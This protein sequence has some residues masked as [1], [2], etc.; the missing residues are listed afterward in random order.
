MKIMEYENLDSNIEE[1]SNKLNIDKDIIEFLINQG[2]NENEINLL[3]NKNYET[4]LPND[5]ITNVKEAAYLIS[6]YIEDNE[7]SIYIFS[8]Y[9]S[10]GIN[11]GYII[12]DTL[13]KTKKALESKCFIDL[14]IP[15]RA[16]GYGLNM[17]WCKEVI[18]DK[19]NKILVITADNGITKK[20]EVAFLKAH[21]I[22][23]LITDHHEPQEKYLPDTLI[24]DPHLHD[25]NNNNALGLC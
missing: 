4:L 20:D 8:D 17:I 12:Y 25:L 24:V 9:D 18:K 1:I 6:N 11:A 15:Q 13:V 22:E 2:Y 19:S 21:N 16:E 14:Y 10:D 23:V 5:N 7:A 3:T